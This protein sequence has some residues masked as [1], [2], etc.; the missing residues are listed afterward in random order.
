MES[1]DTYSEAFEDLLNQTSFV[2][3]K[4]YQITNFYSIEWDQVDEIYDHRSHARAH[5]YGALLKKNQPFAKIEATVSFDVDFKNKTLHN[6]EVCS[7]KVGTGPTCLTSVASKEKKKD[8]DI[9]AFIDKFRLSIEETVLD[10]TKQFNN[11]IIEILEN[12]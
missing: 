10:H 7:V 6:I 9:Q 12:K 4:S 11:S 3:L 2:Q 8:A 1:Q 5:L